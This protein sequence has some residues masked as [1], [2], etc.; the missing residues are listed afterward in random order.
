ML[1]AGDVARE[2]AF[3]R[4]IA[5]IIGFWGSRV[6]PFKGLSD[7]RTGFLLS[8]LDLSVLSGVMF[9]KGIGEALRKEDEGF[10]VTGGLSDV[11]GLTTPCGVFSM[12][13]NGLVGL[14]SLSLDLVSGDRLRLLK[15][16]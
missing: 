12:G 2:L 16:R 8:L 1:A 13:L 14:S 15:V 5:G 6:C 7:L 10:L 9:G 11:N 3:D 4:G